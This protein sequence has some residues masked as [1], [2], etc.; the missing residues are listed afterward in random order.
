MRPSSAIPASIA[1]R[2]VAVVNGHHHQQRRGGGCGAINPFAR[3]SGMG[4]EIELYNEQDSIEDNESELWLSL[5]SHR[6]RVQRHS[7]I[8]LAFTSYNVFRGMTQR[9]AENQ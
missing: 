3:R 9:W 2:R 4:N 8:F 1:N 5:W 7:P 6:S